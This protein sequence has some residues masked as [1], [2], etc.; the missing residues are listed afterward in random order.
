MLAEAEGA[1]LNRRLGERIKEL[2]ALHG[3]AQ[4]LHAGNPLPETLEGVAA[5]LQ[6][7]WQ[8]PEITE[9][10]IA[11]DS[12]E[13]QTPNYRQAPWKQ[14]AVELTS[15][16]RLTRLEIVYLEERSEEN[17]GPFL[18]EERHLLNSVASMLASYFEPRDAEIAV[19]EREARFRAIFAS[20]DIGITILNL[21]GQVIE[22]NSEFQ[23]ILGYTVDELQGMSLAEFTRPEDVAADRKRIQSLTSGKRDH[24]QM[25]R[26]FLRKDGRTAW[27]F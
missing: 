10:R 6:A 17:E 21:E 27:G 26:R 16:G 19:R 11:F 8:Y 25:E 14:E 4:V 22:T 13:Y 9:V 2:T 18:E 12:V 23:W 24:F 1:E 5:I 15:D 3:V 20:A 7:A